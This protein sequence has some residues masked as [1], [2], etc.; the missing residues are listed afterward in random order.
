ML[1]SVCVP[2]E[3]FAATSSGLL[4]VKRGVMGD[5]VSIGVLLPP[6]ER[7]CAEHRAMVLLVK[8]SGGSYWRADVTHLCEGSVS[9]Q[10]IRQYGFMQFN[11]QPLL[12]PPV[13]S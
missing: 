1:K 9:R 13:S 8:E 4:P 6:L 12:V 7:I 11:Q 5:T 3:Y 2:R 10:T